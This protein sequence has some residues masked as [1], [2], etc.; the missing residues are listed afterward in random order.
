MKKRESERGQRESVLD[1]NVEKERGRNERQKGQQEDYSIER[2]KYRND[3]ERR[4][5]KPKNHL[6]VMVATLN[7]KNTLF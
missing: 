2:K 5:M 7:P 6:T 4:K 1:K 3:E